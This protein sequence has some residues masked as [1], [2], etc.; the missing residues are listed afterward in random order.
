MLAKA[1]LLGAHTLRAV[2]CIWIIIIIIYIISVFI[3][4]NFNIP[5]NRLLFS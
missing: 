2:Y 1:F 4:K 3:F 5:I